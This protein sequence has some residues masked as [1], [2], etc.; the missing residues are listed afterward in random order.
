MPQKKPDL[1]IIGPKARINFPKYGVFDVLSKVDTGADSSSVWA[2][3]VKENKGVLEFVLFG[4]TAPWYNGEVIRTKQ[5]SI[6]SIKNSFGTTEFRYK[7]PLSVEING[8]KIRA[9]FTLSNRANNRYP[10]LVGRQT[11]KSRFVV[12]VAHM[13]KED[14]EDQTR[15]LV[16]AHH[17]GQTVRDEFTKIAKTNK[18][19]LEIDVIRYRDLKITIDG[20]TTLIQ[21]INSRRDLSYYDVVYFL[22]RVR[23]AALAAIVAVNAKRLGIGFADSAACNHPSDTKIHQT[24]LLSGHSIS[25]PTTIRID[26]EYLV[27]QYDQFVERLGSPFILKDDNGRKGRGNFLIKNAKEFKD[28]CKHAKNNELEMIA[29]KYIPNKG[30]Y[31]LLVL[32]RRLALVTYRSVDNDQSHLY[33]RDRDGLPKLVDISKIPVHVQQMAIEAAQILQLEVAGVDILQD[34]ETGLWYCLEVNNSPQLVGGAFVPEKMQEL[35]E[36]FIREAKK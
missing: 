6:K 23:D 30:Y 26:N 25:L 28:A 24:A 32:G 10:I 22:T 5:Y 7:V 2:S 3:N 4:P 21:D 29:Q 27:D 35:T 31:R 8:R 34:S 9:R 12:D 1:Q 15:V 33:K 14:K 11:L 36:F 19:K 17:G 13:T 16:L 20:Q 18:D